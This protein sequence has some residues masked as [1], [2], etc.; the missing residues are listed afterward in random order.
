LAISLSGRA[1][2]LAARG[3]API[4]GLVL[5]AP[6][7]L[8]RLRVGPT[9][10]ATTIRWLLRRDEASSAALLGRMADPGADLPVEL[11]TW[12]ALVGRHVRTSLAPPPLPAAALAEVP[13]SRLAG[14]GSPGPVPA[15]QTPY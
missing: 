8:I 2:L 3:D 6:A 15:R 12:I 4:G 11:V 9:V 5:A 13:V 1:A 14:D 7:G 10:L